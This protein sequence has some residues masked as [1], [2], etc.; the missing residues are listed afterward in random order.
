MGAIRKRESKNGKISYQ[1]EV[2]VRGFPRT[3]KT[4]SRLTDAKRWIQSTE[5]AFRTGRFVTDNEATKHTLDE[6]IDRYIEEE[7][8]KKPRSYDSQKR[9]LLWFRKHLGFKLLSDVTPSVLSKCKR[10][11]LKEEIREGVCRKPQ[12]WNRYQAALSCTFQ[13]CCGEWE[14][15]ELNPVR[16]IKREKEPKGRVRFLSD[17]ERE[18]LLE[19]CKESSNPNLYPL[20]VLT[21][22][23]G[24]RRGEVRNL[25]W[26]DVDLKAGAIVLHETKNNERRRVPVKGL[27]LELLKDHSKIRRLDTN[28]VFPGKLSHKTGIGW[29]YRE[30]FE[31]AVKEAKLENFL[32]HDLRHSCASYLAMNGA[33]LL[34]IAEVLGHKTL[35]MVKRYSHLAEGHTAG[36]VERMNEKI[37]G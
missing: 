4:F 20:V 2:R 37:F 8:P 33:S 26:D 14:W 21:L 35:Q 24:M 5:T 30:L 16:R 3:L 22:S 29:E 36:V 34:E 31:R 12:T 7:L 9:Q 23:T 11:F 18:R 27:A 17:E 25:K 28:F 10:T 32:F 6:A 1:A 13:M 19:V 15:M